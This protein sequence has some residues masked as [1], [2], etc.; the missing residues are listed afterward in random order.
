MMLPPIE[1]IAEALC[2]EVSGG[3]VRAPGPGHS[4]K[5]R[6][7]SVTLDDK[8]SDGFVVSL[9]TRRVTWVRGLDDCGPNSVAR[10]TVKPRDQVTTRPQGGLPS[11]GA[12]V[13]WSCGE[14]V[15]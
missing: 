10:V 9:V 7:L 4:A 13:P 2:G 15:G 1:R 8:A 6:S 11:W 3:Q 5:D 12:V 14:M